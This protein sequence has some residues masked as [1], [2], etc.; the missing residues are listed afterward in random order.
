MTI[1]TDFMNSG[2]IAQGLEQLARDYETKV[3][4][5][6]KEMIAEN[7]AEHHNDVILHLMQLVNS[8]QS[9][10]SGGHSVSNMME[11]IKR[12]V[13]SNLLSGM[14]REDARKR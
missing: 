2:E 8:N 6:L 7:D 5:E 1:K 3:S 10:W 9:S 4:E 13:A 11:Q 12:E 14:L